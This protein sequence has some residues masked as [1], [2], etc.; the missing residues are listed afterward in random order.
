MYVVFNPSVDNWIY[1]KAVVFVCT[2]NKV[3][4]EEEDMA[5]CFFF[6]KRRIHYLPILTAFF[7]IGSLFITYG[8][9]VS[10]GHVEPDFP[11]ISYTA[12]KV[13]E[14]CIFAQLINIGSTLLA[15][16]VYIRY[17]TMRAML[18][19]TRR[20]TSDRK[21]NI[22]T[23]IMG[24][25]SALGLS[26]VANFQ[27][28]DIKPAH[29]VG[30]GLAFILGTCYC[31]VQSWLSWKLRRPLNN[32]LVA[33]LQIVNS[34]FLT[35]FLIIFIISKAVYKLSEIHG[36]GTKHDT[37][38]VPYLVSTATEWLT[39]G[40]IVTFVLTFIPDFR[41][42]ILR[43]PVVELPQEIMS[44]INSSTSISTASTSPSLSSNI[45]ARHTLT[46]EFNHKDLKGLS[47]VTENLLPAVTDA[48]NP[49]SFSGHDDG[50][51]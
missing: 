27:T 45:L 3:K 35:C 15:F 25:L 51:V 43:G 29:Y 16:N 22:A 4:T 14:R 20:L 31:W 2:R 50:V 9:S 23:L 18:T 32:T 11:Y 13:P 41:K 1:L 46:N 38:R 49:R 24:F 21:W 33:N 42:S 30:A 7:I 34:V 48:S 39:A 40:S 6:L 17:L 10:Q 47:A 36:L 28:V 26:M 12:I 37:L 19:A 8:V 5:V 44:K